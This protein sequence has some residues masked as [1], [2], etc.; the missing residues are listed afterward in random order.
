MNRL[1]EAVR[2]LLERG[3]LAPHRHRALA[4]QPVAT[5][6][7]RWPKPRIRVRHFLTSGNRGRAT[8]GAEPIAGQSRPLGRSG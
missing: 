1:A 6:R 7:T 3:L 4:M 5:T 8:R 2:R